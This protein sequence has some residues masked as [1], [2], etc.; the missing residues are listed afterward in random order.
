MDESGARNSIEPRSDSRTRNNHSNEVCAAHQAS[1]GI[2][3]RSGKKGPLRQPGVRKQP[4]GN[5]IRRDSRDL[6]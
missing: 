4:V 2:G 5:V 1:A 3:H 6:A